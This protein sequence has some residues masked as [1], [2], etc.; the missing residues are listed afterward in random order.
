LDDFGTGY[1][2]LSYLRSF[3]FDKVKIDRSFVRDIGADGSAAAIVQAITAMA[4]SL[5]MT[6]TAEGIE[7]LDQEAVLRARGCAQ[8]QG[9]L[10]SRP[11]PAEA[12]ARLLSGEAVAAA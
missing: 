12:A 3:P 5:G 1:S 4:A 2:S 10:Y 6:T 9:F 7:T 8:A 11:L